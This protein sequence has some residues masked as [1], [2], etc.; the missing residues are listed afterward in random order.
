MKINV[1]RLSGETDIIEYH[2]RPESTIANLKDQ[3]AAKINYYR[4]SL[5]ICYRGKTLEDNM[6]LVDAKLEEDCTVVVV[7]NVPTSSKRK[8]EPIIGEEF[9]R[10]AADD[11]ERLNSHAAK[12]SQCDEKLVKEAELT[13]MGFVSEKAK[14]ALE[15]YH[16]DLEKAVEYLIDGS[17]R[18]SDPEESH[19]EDTSS[20]EMS[21]EAEHKFNEIVD[22]ALDF[23]EKLRVIP[24][25]E[26]ARL[27]VV[28]KQISP[29]EF[30]ESIYSMHP[31]LREEIES[32]WDLWVM[33][34][35]DG[36]PDAENVVLS[37][38]SSEENLE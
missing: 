8:R 4:E 9:D 18:H 10:Q 24:K 1:R 32:H 2:D 31:K 16:Y 3:I 38:Y 28:E 15:K 23:F 7:G 20:Y 29:K 17:Q 19:E 25:F 26:E 33:V 13:A 27:H 35:A 14:E 30:A 5:K 37:D 21:E 34:V 12:S 11:E 36:I 6:K 22:G